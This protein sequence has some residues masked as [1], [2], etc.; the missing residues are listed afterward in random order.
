MRLLT[1][2]DAALKKQ[3]KGSITYMRGFAL[4]RASVGYLV[5]KTL[6]EKGQVEKRMQGSMSLHQ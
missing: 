1:F 4:Q 2:N 3:N 5:C 6:G